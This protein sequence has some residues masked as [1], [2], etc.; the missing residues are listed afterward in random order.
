MRALVR[1]LEQPPAARRLHAHA[2]PESGSSSFSPP[3]ASPVKWRSTAVLDSYVE[4]DARPISLRQLIFFG[5]RNLDEKRIL[6]SANYVRTELPVRLAHRIRDMQKLPYVVVT[7]R[8]LSHVYELYYKA[9]DAMRQVPEMRTLK[10]NDRFCK[11]L[12]GFLQEHLTV[13]P[14][15]AMGVQEC[16]SLLPAADLDRFM[17]S[18]LRSVRLP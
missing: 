18:L 15:L 2:Q 1:C 5:G 10:D 4:K 7:N 13:I 12:K 17:S 11:V 6:N 9:F 8:H 14:R 3:V 16:R